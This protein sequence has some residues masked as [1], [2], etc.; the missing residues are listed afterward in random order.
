[1]SGKDEA[2][3]ADKVLSNGKSETEVNLEQT[4]DVTHLQNSAAPSEQGENVV[5]ITATFADKSAGSQRN[6]RGK[7]LP[8]PKLGY[9]A[10]KYIGLL[11]MT[12]SQ[13]AG[14]F[15]VRHILANPVSDGDS[16]LEFLNVIKNFGVLTMPLLLVAMTSSIINKDE[17]IGR[18]VVKNLVCTVLFYIAEVLVFLFYIV[19]TV[20]QLIKDFAM[21]EFDSAQI[22]VD[23]LGEFSNVNIF[24]DL[25]LCSLIYMFFVYKPKRDKIPLALWRLFTL[26]PVAFIVAS[27]AVNGLVKQG[28]LSVNFYVG[29]LL[30]HKKI[31]TYV[32]FFVTLIFV[33]YKPQ[34]Y[35]A[36]KNHRYANYDDYISSNSAAYHHNAFLIFLILILSLIDFGISYIPNIASWGIGNSYFLF[37]AVPFLLFF[38][39]R[40]EPKRKIAVKLVPLYYLFNYILLAVLYL[41]CLF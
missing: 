13:I 1:M 25:F 27:F 12:I 40:R 8:K 4:S 9:T 14:F 22:L 39:Y 26:L 11:F 15:A 33:K 37:A 2:I 21:M 20:N 6:G 36:A 35:S 10:V 3:N 38:D 41:Y 17:K 5:V 28:A 30:P 18:V 32:F 16:L 24:I 34:L 7:L 29:A 31:V 19:P 23:M